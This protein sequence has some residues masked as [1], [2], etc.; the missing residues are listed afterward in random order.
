M[1]LAERRTDGGAAARLSRKHARMGGVRA[2]ALQERPRRNARHSG[3]RNLGGQGRNALHGLS[4]RHSRGG[5]RI[6]RHRTRVRRRTLDGR[7]CRARI[8]RTASA[9]DGRHS[10]AQFDPECRQRRKAEEPRTRNRAR[11]FGQEGVARARRSGGRF[12][13]RQ[14]PS[15]CSRT[16]TT[17]PK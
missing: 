6:A 17:S 2:A 15:P 16:S 5:T 1:R 7:V 3:T 10:A 11:A 4:R 12:R 9:D 8:L 14:P 13:S